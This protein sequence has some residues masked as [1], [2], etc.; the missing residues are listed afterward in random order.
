MARPV[1]EGGKHGVGGHWLGL[2]C[3]AREFGVAVR[4]APVKRGLQLSAHKGRNEKS[5]RG[6][7][8]FGGGVTHHI[9]L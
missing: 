2:D 1:G 4:L 6:P 9:F 8:E 7:C 3:S 5:F